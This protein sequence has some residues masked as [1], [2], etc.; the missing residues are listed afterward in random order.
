MAFSIYDPASYLDPDDGGSMFLGNFG[1]WNVI[2]FSC[3][4]N[5]FSWNSIVTI[6]CPLFFTST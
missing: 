2:V 5:P 1:D 6:L 3:H 4:S